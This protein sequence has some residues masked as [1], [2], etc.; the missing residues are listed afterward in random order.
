MLQI[1]F[2]TSLAVQNFISYFFQLLGNSAGPGVRWRTTY[3]IQSMYYEARGWRHQLE[4]RTARNTDQSFNARFC[5]LAQTF[6]V[7]QKTVILL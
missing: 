4:L 5:F 6:L 2:C 1:S 3:V 7:K